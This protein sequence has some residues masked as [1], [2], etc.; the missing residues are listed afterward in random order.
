MK[1][2]LDFRC[3]NVVNF[4]DFSFRYMAAIPKSADEFNPVF[5]TERIMELV[6]NFFV[7]E[8]YTSLIRHPSL[9][10]CIV[11]RYRRAVKN[12]DPDAFLKSVEEYNT[13]ID[14][15]RSDG[16]IDT[17]LLQQQETRWGGN[18]NTLP[19]PIS[20]LILDQV[21]TRVVSPVT[22]SLRDYKAF[23]NNVYG[24]LL[25]VFMTRIFKETGLEAEMKFIDLGSGVGNCV[26]QAAL[27]IG[28]ESWG[29]EMMKTASQLAA[30]QKEEIEERVK[31]YGISVGLVEVRSADFVHNDEIHKQISEADVL[32]VNNYAFDGKLNSHLL[33]IFLD[34][35]EGARIISLKSFVPPG[36]VIS[37]HNIQSPVNLLRV[38]PKEFPTGSVSWTMASGRYYLSTVDR[39]RLDK[40]L[41]DHGMI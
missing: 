9:E 1:S 15:L 38:E 33:D 20:R 32:L 27:E 22:D 17:H 12:K 26:L 2:Q 31:M 21:Y 36:H 28:C 30:K 3:Y 39:T 13:L 29:C 24:E 8:N 34:L 35:K 37:Q 11:R 18:I 19:L 40:F 23:S 6:A 10:D 14:K 16:A 25:P 5:E 7:P 4:F 41:K